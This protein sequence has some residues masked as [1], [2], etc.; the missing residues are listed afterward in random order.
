MVPLR[1]CYDDGAAEREKDRNSQEQRDGKKEEEKK[2]KTVSKNDRL[3]IFIASKRAVLIMLKY[4]IQ[5]NIVHHV[6]SSY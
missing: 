4:G 6:L 1:D 2:K 3:F 5:K